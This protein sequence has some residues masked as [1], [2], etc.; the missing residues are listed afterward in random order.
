MN[1]FEFLGHLTI[2]LEERSRLNHAVS[3]H[4]PAFKQLLRAFSLSGGA[5]KSDE[6]ARLRA[7]EESGCNGLDGQDEHLYAPFLD[8]S[9]NAVHYAPIPARQNHGGQNHECA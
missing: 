6:L 1:R 4:D 9:V 8:D 7:A 5:V 3:A 2:A